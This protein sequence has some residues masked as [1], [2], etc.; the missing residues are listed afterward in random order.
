[1]ATN[2]L[3]IGNSSKLN[4]I[5][6][7]ITHLNRIKLSSIDLVLRSPK[8][9]EKLQFPHFLTAE[10]YITGFGSL[11][12]LTK[13]GNDSMIIGYFAWHF[14]LMYKNSLVRYKKI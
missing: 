1:M 9:Y 13:T 7:Q 11:V 10:N 3:S 4:T 14:L 6:S 5:R 12:V 2:L 8:R